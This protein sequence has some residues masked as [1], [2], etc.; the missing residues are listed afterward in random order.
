MSGKVVEAAGVIAPAS[1]VGVSL[2]S[3]QVGTATIGTLSPY[4][5]A[6]FTVSLAKPAPGSY[7]VTAEADVHHDVEESSEANQLATAVVVI[8]QP[9]PP[10][11]SD[12]PDLQVQSTSYAG[13]SRLGKVTYQVTVKNAGQKTAGSFK[14]KVTIPE[15]GKVFVKSYKSISP[16]LT[17]TQSFSFTTSY[18][19]PLTFQVIVDSDSQVLET[20]EINNYFE[21]RKTL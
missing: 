20:N 12:A 13:S 1:V 18:R 16:N 5:E 3:G 6:T 2:S 15:I 9:P 17:R 19:G 8:P 10:V 4:G 14:V 11:P 7:T 21:E